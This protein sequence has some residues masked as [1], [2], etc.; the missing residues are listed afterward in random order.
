[1]HDRGAHPRL[2]SDQREKGTRSDEDRVCVSN[3]R[4]AAL[5]CT[6]TTAGESLHGREGASLRHE[7]EKPW[8]RALQMPL[9]SLSLFLVQELI[10]HACVVTGA[11]VRE[12]ESSAPRYP[13]HRTSQSE[14]RSGVSS[15][16][17]DDLFQFG[18]S[19]A[20]AH[21]GISGSSTDNAQALGQS[22]LSRSRPAADSA[23]RTA[24]QQSYRDVWSW[25]QAYNQR[26]SQRHHVFHTA[27]ISIY[28]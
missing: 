15:D 18:Q 17:R 10:N 8:A 4:N 2:G 24:R 21:T 1:M 22:T 14:R 3:T 25:R 23:H 20:G 27:S 28:W 13:A 9:P 26:A 11:G 12:R 6:P 19:G 5:L 7:N 16:V